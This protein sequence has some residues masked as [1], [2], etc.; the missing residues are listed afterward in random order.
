[1][2]KIIGV[3]LFISASAFA[4]DSIIL[5]SDSI[6]EEGDHFTVD[7]VLSGIPLW[8]H[9]PYPISR[10]SFAI[11]RMDCREIRECA[12][13]KPVV[14]REKHVVGSIDAHPARVSYRFVP[15]NPA[16]LA[17]TFENGAGKTYLVTKSYP[18]SVR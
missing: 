7:L 11:P 18:A 17:L 2:K 14:V 15:G 1:M 6:R 4:A 16:T 8:S 13:V 5:G 3:L 9:S 12:S 10:V